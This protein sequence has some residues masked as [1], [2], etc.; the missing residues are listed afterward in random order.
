MYLVTLALTN[1]TSSDIYN[2]FF[3]SNQWMHMSTCYLSEEPFVK[4]HI[5]QTH[6]VTRHW[7]ENTLKLLSCIDRVMILVACSL[8]TSNI[9]FKDVSSLQASSTTLSRSSKNK[10][11]CL[12]A[13]I[14]SQLLDFGSLIEGYHDVV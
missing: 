12:C 4:C 2:F 3:L 9:S 8:A 13:P 6:L 1:V 14:Q 11:N 10:T 5:D 7:L